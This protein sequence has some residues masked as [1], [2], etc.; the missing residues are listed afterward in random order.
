MASELHI[1]TEGATS[2]MVADVVAHL[3]HLERCWSRFIPNSDI[4]RINTTRVGGLAVDDSTITLLASMIEGHQITGGGY[5][6]TV[7]PALVEQGYAVS[8]ED[9]SRVTILGQDDVPAS[10]VDA[11]EL[12]PAAGMVIVPP[13]LAL[14]PGGIGKGLAADL[15]VARLMALGAQ[16]ALVS[17][18]GDL[19]M[20]GQAVTDVGWL[21]RVE[22]ADPAD[23]I[24]CTLAVSEGGVATSSTRS[25]RWMLDGVE[26]HHQI[27][28]A[29]GRPSTTDLAAVTVIARSGWLAEVHATA[30]MACGSVGVVQYLADHGLS[31]IAVE[32]DGRIL[33]SPDLADVEMQ[34]AAG[35]R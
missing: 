6:P 22:Q 32:R 5:D 33:V 10:K 24:L 21:V 4:S 14:D 12:D 18:G 29:T 8:L 9:P 34:P 25:R 1:I 15:A 28:P 20:A 2:A 19:A 11:L 27:D 7:L 23:G 3:E 17:I 13:G 30:A 26:R 16:G 31:G 35:A